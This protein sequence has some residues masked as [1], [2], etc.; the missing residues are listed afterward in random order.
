[1]DLV[2]DASNLR[3]GG[4]VTHLSNVLAAGDP[5]PFGIENVEVWTNAKTAQRIQPRSW[6]QV[7]HHPS[8]EQG[9][10]Q[11]TLWQRKWLD[12]YLRDRKQVL[13]W[14]PGGSYLGS[15]RPFVTMS[16]SLLPFEPD[17]RRH[18][19]GSMKGLRLALLRRTQAS[20][21]RR[22]QGAIFLTRFA[23]E[24]VLEQ[25]GPLPC[26]T[27][28]IPHGVD[29]EFLCAPRLSRPFEEFT[30]ANPARLLYVSPLTFYKN[31]IS[32]MEAVALLRHQGITAELELVGP[33]SERASKEAFLAARRRLDP[34]EKFIKFTGEL[35]YAK[36]FETYR[37]AD[38][39]LF[40][41]SVETFG[42]ILVEA[43]AAGLPVAASNRSAIPEVSGEAAVFFDP[44][45]PE[46]IAAATE[47]LLR[48]AALRDEMAGR[49]YRR[50]QEFSWSK[51]ADATFE[52]LRQCYS[53][54]GE[55][56]LASPRSAV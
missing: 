53:Q 25:I 15:F 41:S 50:A 8:L 49:A 21:L 42:N 47:K 32:V 46:Q 27:A 20:T 44:T 13:L 35:P 19:R 45:N 4:G 14:V 51:C 2:I 43:M 9:T 34:E 37:K 1:M 3:R 16:R 7:H 6:L 33:A 38:L 56:R 24:R 39:F 40:A 28:T 26:P 55:F 36:L 23:R 31:T 10:F 29:S 48:N 17:A 5:R 30:D 12:R 11:R 54:A 18:Y 52:F 22:S